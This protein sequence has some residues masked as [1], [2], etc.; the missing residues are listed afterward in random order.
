MKRIVEAKPLPNYRLFVRFEDGAKGEVDLSSMVGNGVF[1]SWK[2][3]AVFSRVSIDSATG[4]VTWP[5]G[6][7]LCPDT[8]Y[9]YVTGAP[10]TGSSLAQSI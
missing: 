1:A 6:I 9:S 5:D 4:T 10:V 8:L 2:D 7:D 3:Q